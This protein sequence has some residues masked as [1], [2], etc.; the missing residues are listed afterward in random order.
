MEGHHPRLNLFETI[1]AKKS[2]KSEKQCGALHA[3][4]GGLTDHIRSSGV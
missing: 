4:L 3:H 1:W 2:K